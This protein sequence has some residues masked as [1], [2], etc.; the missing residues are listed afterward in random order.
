[1]AVLR[2][3]TKFPHLPQDSDAFPIGVQLDQRVQG[4]FHGIG[5][6]VVAVVEKMHAPDFFDLQTRFGKWRSDETDAAIL[7]GKTKDASGANCEQRVLHHVQT[8]YRQ[9][10]TATVRT[11][12]YR[13]V[14]SALALTD[15]ARTDGSGSRAS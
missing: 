3:G 8:R 14:C 10:C 9:L 1:M 12:Q 5:V 13:K 4:R 15:F 7:K 6:C 11:L 2:F